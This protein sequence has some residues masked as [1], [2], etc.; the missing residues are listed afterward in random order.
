[1]VSTRKLH[2]V[3]YFTARCGI[4]L[5]RGSLSSA[6]HVRLFQ[7]QMSGESAGVQSIPDGYHTFG[8]TYRQFTFS[9][10]WVLETGRWR[11]AM[12]GKSSTPCNTIQHESAAPILCTRNIG[13]ESCEDKLVVTY[14]CS[15]CP[16]V[17][18]Q[19]QELGLQRDRRWGNYYDRGNSPTSPAGT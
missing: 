11:R 1:M 5:Q 4:R 3:L 14:R 10:F 16:Y 15:H 19:D 2:H 9:L 8:E 12:P 6:P 18:D 17:L 7:L 13:M